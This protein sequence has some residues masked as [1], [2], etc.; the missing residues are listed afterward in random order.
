MVYIK[1]DAKQTFLLPTDLRT[2]I[3]KDHI[4]YL[5]ESVV[6]QLDYT[7]FDK[8]VEGPGNP[9]YHPRVCLKIILNGVCER[10]TSTRKLEKSTSENIIFRYLS[11]NLNPNFHTIAMFRRTNRD[12]IKQCFLQ[13]VEIAKNLNMTNFNKL[14]LDGVK[15]KAN[16]SKSKNF[17]KEEINFLSEFVDEQLEKMDKTDE[18]EDKKY[19]DS[20][21]EPKIPEH[22]TSQRK[23]KEKIKQIMKDLNKAKKQMNKAKAKI[24]QEGVDKVNLTDMD[25]KMMKMKKGKHYE[26][27]YNCQL[28]IE[29][30]SGIIV[31]NYLSDSPVDVTETKPTM[32]K[33]KQEQKINLRGVE[34]FQDNGYSSSI[35]AE[36]YEEEGVIAYI[37]DSVTTKELHGKAKNISKFNNDSFELDIKKNQAICP[38]GHRMNFIRRQIKSKKSGNWTNVYKTD[39]CG[40]CKLRKEC[41]KGKSQKKFREAEINPLMRKI[42]LRF[43]T[44]EGLEKYNKRFHKGEVPQAH[45]F[46]NLSYREFKC[47]EKKPCENEKDLFSSAYNL[48]KI[49]NKLRDIGKNL[50]KSLKIHNKLKE[51]GENLEKKIK[52]IFFRLD[53]HFFISES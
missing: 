30:K 8:K 18:E 52:I 46:H 53:Y 6:D 26:Q 51:M 4:C 35:T 43:K 42:R 47:R 22:L 29:D 38:A 33:F 14:Y 25:S 7:M 39:K 40:N 44:K 9:S 20:N 2:I 16:A 11:E 21:G 23:L 48:K 15:V 49:H 32:G 13:T 37:P 27:A 45:I 24:E 28:L 1:S 50:E 19:G 17:S 34:V 41:I 3:P 12:L 36:Y 10:I 5:I 31:G